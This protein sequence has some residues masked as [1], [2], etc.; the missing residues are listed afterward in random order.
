MLRL[1]PEPT[2]KTAVII[3]KTASEEK[4]A[5]AA[6]P[7]TVKTEEQPEPTKPLEFKGVIKPG[8]SLSLAFG[9]FDVDH[10]K[11]TQVALALKG[12]YDFRQMSPGT[13]WDARFNILGEL[14]GFTLYHD[15]LQTF[16]VRREGGK[17]EGYK[18]T[19]ETQMYVHAISGRIEQ[20]LAQSIW[21][22]NESEALTAML[23]EIFQW[24]VDFFSDM[25]PG[26]EW[27]LMVEKH[28][29]QGKFV[30]Y[31]R[32]LC[33]RLKGA[34]I[35]ELYAYYFQSGDKAYQEYFDDK[36]WAVRKNFLR[37]PLDTTRVT[38]RFG[39]RSHPVSGKYKKHNGVDYGAPRGT[40]VWNIARG[41][42]L[43]A[44]WMGDCGKGVKVRHD[45]G[46]ESIYCHLS[47]ISVR[48]GQSLRQK[49]KIGNVGC[50]G[51]CTGPHLHF[52]L[53]RYGKYMNPLKVKYVPGKRLGKRY[54]DR[55]K[56]ARALLKGRLDALSASDFL[57]PEPAPEVSD[58]IAE[59]GEETDKKAQAI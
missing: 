44:G 43:K 13:H 46:Y 48:R 19:G 20:S 26:D 55:W 21:K 1:F 16:H 40:S 52:G 59:S 32:I 3:E 8:E 28:F 6:I 54:R 33:A 25:Q 4:V 37:A 29:Y 45:H 36:G 2:V 39:F 18:I 58:P 50:T 12:I 27:H 56:E 53:K 7:S 30:K 41:K 14:E 31:G 47:R 9:R 11:A 22:L 42:V 5:L 57:G 38:S 10:R 35:G 51:V 34:A 15:P 17:L 23:A 24:D 49:D